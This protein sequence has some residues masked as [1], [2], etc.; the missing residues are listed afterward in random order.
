MVALVL[1]LSII[2]VQRAAEVF[3][4]SINRLFR[5]DRT[6]RFIFVTLAVLCLLSFALPTTTGILDGRVLLFMQIVIIA[7]TLDLLRWY[8]RHTVRLLEPQEPLNR[9]VRA[10]KKYIDQIQQTVSRQA[11]LQWG[12]LTEEQKRN[13]S[14]E[15]FESALY[16]KVFSRH[17]DYINALTS[18]LAEI[19]LKA[20]A[21]G[22]T[23]TAEFVVFGLAEIACYY[24]GKRKR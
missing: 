4:P 8:H 22:E 24:I 17:S 10:I 5:Q 15:D 23:R 9:L 13:N 2:P 1:S 12:T 16:L 11:R 3:S 18:E 7:L 14:P 19:A 21:R 6:T 20:V